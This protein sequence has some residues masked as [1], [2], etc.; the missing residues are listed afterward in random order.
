MIGEGA[1]PLRA[2]PGIIHLLERR[3][4]KHLLWSPE[5]LEEAVRDSLKHRLALAERVPGHHVVPAGDPLS[6]LAAMPLMARSDLAE[7]DRWRDPWVPRALTREATSSGSSGRPLTVVRDPSSVIYEEAFLRRQL[8]AF[9][10]EPGWTALSIRADGPLD[11][12]GPVLDR[13]PLM[14][15][16]TRVAASRLDDRAVRRVVQWGQAEGVRLLRGYPSALL[17][18]ARRVEALDLA[19]ELGRWPLRIVNVSSETVSREGEARLRRVFG[20]PVADHYGQAERALAIQSCPSGARHL[21]T[22]YGW[23]E[24]VADR[25]VGTPLFGRGMV[26][27]R[28]ATEDEAAPLEPGHPTS[29]PRGCDCGWPFPVVG[30]VLGRAD[31]V[32]VTTDGRRIG[33]IGPGISRVQGLEQVQIEQ[34]EIG[35]LIVRVLLAPR[36]DRGGDDP[37]RALHASL[38]RLLGDPDSVLE[39]RPGE[40]PVPGPGGKVR[41]VVSTLAVLEDQ[42][43]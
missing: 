10:W 28:Y 12:E 18:L 23:G 17:E 21:I 1:G 15:N 4:A 39:M 27:V 22:D 43:V 41:T 19:G 2:P 31:D 26:L 24:V 20:A 9:G 3:L 34:A 40:P 6:T 25:W 8:R 16:T 38:S 11:P 32:V 42:R 14:R 36:P 5:R 33:R 30:R 13:D 35:R 29:A 7:P 37:V